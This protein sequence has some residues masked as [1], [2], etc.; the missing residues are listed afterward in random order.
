MI[1]G[2][3]DDLHYKGHAELID[4]WPAVR[5]AVPDAVL[6]IV[7]SGPGTACHRQQANALGLTPEQVEFRGFVPDAELDAIWASTTVFAMPSRGEGFG[8]VYAEAMRHG[9]PVVASVHDAG[10]EVNVDGQTGYNVKLDRL[11]ELTDRL[12]HLLRHPDHAAV[13]GAAGRERWEQCFRFSSFRERFLPR[14]RA[15]V[16]A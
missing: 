10:Q 6:T 8:L 13:L 5:Q 1:L 11:D 7:G 9:I 2:R 16:G 4:S 14:L 3:I 12:I 15:F